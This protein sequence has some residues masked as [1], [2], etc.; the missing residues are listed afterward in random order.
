MEYDESKVMI[1]KDVATFISAKQTE[2]V[3]MIHTLSTNPGNWKPWIEKRGLW[4]TAQEVVML[5]HGYGKYKNLCLTCW[6]NPI[7]CGADAMKGPTG[8]VCYCEVYKSKGNL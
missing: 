1:K 6:K 2:V 4:F 8:N 7:S 3:K 5:K